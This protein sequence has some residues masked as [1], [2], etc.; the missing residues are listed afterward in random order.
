MRRTFNGAQESTKRKLRLR[1]PSYNRWR[2]TINDI[3]YYNCYEIVTKL[4]YFD[5]SKE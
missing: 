1:P 3:R 5:D 4:K 2:V